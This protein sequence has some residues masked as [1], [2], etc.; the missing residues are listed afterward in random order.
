MK[1][2]PPIV[3]ILTL[4]SCASK[5]V[6][7]PNAKLKKV[8]KEASKRDIERCQ[9]EADEFLESPRGK[10]ILKSAGKGAIAGSAIGA[11]TG[12]LSGDIIGGALFGGAVGGTAGG[13]GE[14]LSP[15]EIERRYVNRCLHNKGYEVIGW[16]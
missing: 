16:E 10:Q 1:L 4:T 11:V 13:V 2:I 9:D 3:L 6:L 5:P 14:A 12:L 8:G 7:Y 15:D